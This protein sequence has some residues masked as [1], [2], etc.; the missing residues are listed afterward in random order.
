MV[1]ITER[2]KDIQN[3]IAMDPVEIIFTR[4]EEIRQS[5]GN[6]LRPV[7]T[8]LEPVM[9]RIFLDSTPGKMRYI[10]GKAIT[11]QHILILDHTVK[12]EDSP[13]ITYSFINLYGAFKVETVAANIISGEIAGYQCY[14]TRESV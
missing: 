13:S 8:T 4:V 12:I 6:V 1:P 14:I 7:T 11:S 2:R 9:G 10:G 5:P 3:N